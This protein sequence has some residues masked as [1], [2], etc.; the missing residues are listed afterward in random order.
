MIIVEN[1]YPQVREKNYVDEI[2]KSKYFRRIFV[3]NGLAWAPCYGN[4]Y[5][6]WKLF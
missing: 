6:V 4:F 1:D 3:R 2:L 5:E